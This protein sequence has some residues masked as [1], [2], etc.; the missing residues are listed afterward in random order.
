MY[1]YKNMYCST[2]HYITGYHLP[3]I[4]LREAKNTQKYSCFLFKL[5]KSRKFDP[6]LQNNSIY[7][8]YIAIVLLIH[9]AFKSYDNKTGNVD[10]TCF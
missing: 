5:V 3:H 6:W 9:A 4:F 2:L 1:T 10:L 7:I 8:L